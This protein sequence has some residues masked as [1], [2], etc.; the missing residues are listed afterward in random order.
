MNE[1][2]KARFK[3]DAKT[4]GRWELSMGQLG[5]AVKRISLESI[6]SFFLPQ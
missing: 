1:P 5:P 6:Q 3:A 4:A 2:M